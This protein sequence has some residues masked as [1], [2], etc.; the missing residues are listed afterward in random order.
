MHLLSGKASD[1][2]GHKGIELVIRDL[3]AFHNAREIV[4]N[5]RS[6]H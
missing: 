2:N 3:T 6:G 1:F 4:E 5:Y